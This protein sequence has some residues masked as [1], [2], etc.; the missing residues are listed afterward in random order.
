MTMTAPPPT[1]VTSSALHSWE[2]HHL[3]S[4][5]SLPSRHQSPPC[6]LHDRRGLR[7]VCPTLGAMCTHNRGLRDSDVAGVVRCVHMYVIMLLCFVDFRMLTL[8]FHL[9]SAQS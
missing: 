6:A 4:H 8:L 3:Y 1:T 7:P 2:E 9:F 5:R